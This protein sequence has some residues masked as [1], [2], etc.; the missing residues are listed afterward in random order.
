MPTVMSDVVSP[1]DLQ[2][3]TGG[4]ESVNYLLAV[5]NDG[6]IVRMPLG[7]LSDAI[8]QAVGEH[9]NA[10]VHTPVDPEG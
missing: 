1:R 10:F 5:R 8:A 2:V 6:T 7:L 9:E 4:L 3:A